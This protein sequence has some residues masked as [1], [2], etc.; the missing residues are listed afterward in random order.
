M[1]YPHLLSHAK[2]IIS[3]LVVTKRV[4]RGPDFKGG[5]NSYRQVQRDLMRLLGDTSAAKITTM[6]DYYALPTDF[7]GHATA[8]ASP[9]AARVEHLETAFATDISDQRFVPYLSQHEF[10]ALLFVDPGSARW[11]YDSTDVVSALL[12]VRSE[13]AGQPELINNGA[14][15]APSKRVEAIFPTYQ[16]P[17][18]GPLA[19]AAAGLGALRASCPHFGQWVST[20]ER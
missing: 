6:L 15:T 19:S 10:E 7:P 16:K 11:V 8:P 17:L 1:L 14:L 2:V 5:V 20:L 18:H 12:N 4:K 3:T 13:F 9:P